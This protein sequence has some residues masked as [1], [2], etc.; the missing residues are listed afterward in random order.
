MSAKVF[1]KEELSNIPVISLPKAYQRA[2]QIPLDPSTI[3]TSYADAA[4][5]ANGLSRFG[6]ISYA[7]QILSVIDTS[8]GTVTI[9]KIELDSSLSVLGEAKSSA[10][11]ASTYSDAVLLAES[12]NI[13]T[14]INV[15]S[16]ETIGQDTYSEGL[17]IVVGNNAISKLGVTSASGDVEGD[18]ENLKGRVGNLES[19]IQA[20]YWET[21]EDEE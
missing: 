21:D 10:L 4:E 14:I 3:F 19:I 18:V 5:Y 17:Y 8:G 6:D 15:L 16:A 11:S 1:T 20:L 7:G 2:D 13:G 12:D 9:Y